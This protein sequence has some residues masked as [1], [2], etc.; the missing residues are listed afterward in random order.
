MIY[1]SLK[2]GL[3]VYLRRLAGKQLVGAIAI[4]GIDDF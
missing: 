4:H 1:P 3:I 2:L